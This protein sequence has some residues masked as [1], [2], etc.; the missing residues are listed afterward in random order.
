MITLDFRALKP[1]VAVQDSTF[2]FV[3]PEDEKV[4]E[5][6][7]TS[8]VIDTI[9]ATAGIKGAAVDAVEPQK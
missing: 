2:E 8:Q 6:D 9:K 7:L 3:R 5:T 1:N 4:V